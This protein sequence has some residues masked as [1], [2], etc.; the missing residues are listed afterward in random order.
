M[1]ALLVTKDRQTVLEAISKLMK[2][3]MV[4]EGSQYGFTKDHSILTNSIDIYAE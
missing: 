1:L 2:N 4:I 3:K